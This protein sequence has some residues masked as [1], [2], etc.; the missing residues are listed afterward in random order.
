MGHRHYLSQN[1]KWRSEKGSFDGTIEKRPPPKV[2]ETYGSLKFY[3]EFAQSHKNARHLSNV[4]WSRQFIES[5]KDR[6]T[7]LHKQDDSQ[8]MED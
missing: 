6:V 5:F 7:Q 8:I 4:E 3:R 1:H 2:H